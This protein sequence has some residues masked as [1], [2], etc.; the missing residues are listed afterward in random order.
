MDSTERSRHRHREAHLSGRAT[1]ANHGRPDVLASWERVSLAGVDPGG[2]PEIAPLTEVEVHERRATGCLEQL[3]PLLE[4]ALRPVVDSGQLV[5][6]G[7]ADGRVL[8]RLGRPP[9]RRRADDLGF[10]AGSA[11]TEGNVGTNAIGTA[12]VLGEPVH[13]H[14]A[15]H[16]VESHAR[17]AC[18]A[19]PLHD[20]WTGRMV[21]VVDISGPRTS[22]H[23]T[24]LSTVGLAARVASLELLDRHRRSL[25]DLRSGSAHLLSRTKGPAAIVDRTGHVAASSGLAP[26]GTIALPD[27]LQPGSAHLPGLGQVVVEPVP[28]GWLLRP[29]SD[30]VAMTRA[31]LD[32]DG[33]PSIE[34]V[35]E[36][37]PWSRTLTPRHAEML[38]SLVR[39]GPEGLSAAALAEQI[40]ADPTRE[41]TVR[42][43]MSRLRKVL[44]GL[45]LAR[46]YRLSG[47]VDVVARWPTDTSLLLPG[48]SAPVVHRTRAWLGSAKGAPPA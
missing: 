44:G 42:A 20:P 30:Q 48:S 7:D 6:I 2:G 22:V 35:A 11:W 8:W 25:E 33:E 21:G 24:L 19:A 27:D 17:W 43:E 45:V 47:S 18:A 32:L 37:G 28:G 41:V 9:A 38:L 34:V 46:P 29:S 15:E 36:S 14:G 39:A 31:V 13:I 1:G 40:F 4:A 3:V 12:L 10:V 26:H 16:F 5:V 23:P